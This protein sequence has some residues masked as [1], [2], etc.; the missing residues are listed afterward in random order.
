MA[1]GIE[2]VRVGHY[3]DSKGVTGCTVVLC[4]AGAVGGVDVSGASPGTRETDLVRPGLLVQQVQGVMLSGGSAFG[5]DAA[6]GAMRYLEER[7]CGQQTSAGVVPIVP[8]A[9]LFD[10]AIGDPK[11]RPG[12]EEGYQSCRNAVDGVVEEGSVGAGTGATVGKCLGMEHATKGGLGVSSKQLAGETIVSALMAVNPYGDVV[13]PKANRQIAGPRTP[14]RHG[15]ERTTRLLAEG[16]ALRKLEGMNTVLGVVVTN[17]KL[18]KE[19]ANRLA[20]MAHTGVARTIDPLTMF[21]GDV[22]FALS[23][24][25]QGVDF[26]LLAAGA[27][28]V[29]AEAIVR[30]VTQARGLGG[31]PAACEIRQPGVR[32]EHH[33]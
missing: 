17:A 21:D 27:A 3:T 5:L 32:R 13:D 12:I 23:A 20:Q 4:E 15:F 16:R 29:V 9:I 28:E 10:L 25:L 30:G 6:G 18:S 22:I 31:I 2:P 7:G 19:E 24:G 14:N 26:N 33:H 11:A 1:M 8:A